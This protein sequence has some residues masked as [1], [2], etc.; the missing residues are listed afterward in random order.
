MV[1]CKCPIGPITGF[2]AAEEEAAF[3]LSGAPRLAAVPFCYLKANANEQMK[4]RA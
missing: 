1:D 4:L 2:A 3:A